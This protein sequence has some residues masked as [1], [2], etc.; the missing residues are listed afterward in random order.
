MAALRRAL[1]LE[2]GDLPRM[3]PMFGAYFL[4][5]TAIYV[6]KPARNAL[7]LQGE[8]VAGLPWVLLAVAGAGG[9]TAFAYGKI[10]DRL[11]PDKLVPATFGALA[12][13]LLAFRW[14]LATEARWALYAF[15]VF[16][17]LLGLLT[18][19]LIWL[20]ANSAFD[21][22]EARR[23]FGLIGTG[24]IIGSIVGG[25]LTGAVASRLGT[26]NLLLLAA[27]VLV[28]VVLVLRWAPPLRSSFESRSRRRRAA[29]QDDAGADE[30]LPRLLALNATIIGLV[31]VFVDVQFNSL[32]EK[33]FL[34]A[35]Q[36]AA[37]FGLFFAAISF[38][39][40]GVQLILTPW[41][42]RR[43]GLGPALAALPTA[44]GAGAGLLFAGP[45]F[46]F[47]AAPKAA[48]GGLRHSIHK[49][50]TE[51]VFLP[52]PASVKQRAKLFIDTTVDTAATGVGAL[53]VLGLTGPL[54]WSYAQ[55]SGPVL[56][57]AAVSLWTVGRLRSAY[58]DAFRRALET[59]RLDDT[60][61]TTGMNEAAVAE[62]LQTALQS[63]QPRQLVYLL[64]LAESVGVMGLSRELR[65]LLD[66]PSA[67]VRRRA[68]NLMGH[69]AD[70][71]PI[72]VLDHLIDHDEDPEVQ[73][74]ALFLRLR[75]EGREDAMV[76]MLDGS[77]ARAAAALRV[78]T[79]SPQPDLLTP[80]R[81]ERLRALPEA[82]ATLAS[83]VAASGLPFE[84]TLRGLLENAPFDVVDG[85][86]Q[87]MAKAQDPRFVPWLIE[88]LAQ[89]ELRGAARRTLAALGSI[90]V[91]ALS[92]L[93]LD[94]KAPL[95]A[96]RAAIRTLADVADGP[97]TEALVELLEDD[98]PIISG[99]ALQGLSRV[100]PRFLPR[101]RL[102][103]WLRARIRTARL[104]RATRRCLGGRPEP[105][106]GTRLFQR[107]LEEQWERSL[108]E[109]FSL[110][111][112]LHGREAMRDAYYGL[113]RARA[114]VLEYLDNTIRGGLKDELL[115][116]FE[117]EP[118]AQTLDPLFEAWMKQADP[119]LR[120]TAVYA[121]AELQGPGA[122]AGTRDLHP[123]VQET[124][125]HLEAAS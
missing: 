27:L 119:W 82:R 7:F 33:S 74:E 13:L 93:A 107:T 121:R 26:S 46:P 92:E 71:L 95:A 54:G 61:L 110:L 32:V 38:S 25:A 55:L 87:G 125:Q 105:G 37:F 88:A 34:E 112:L 66:H 60:A 78:L 91:P 120:A 104:I 8:G 45:G 98:Q 53:L 39:S 64:D 57:L 12:V 79:E 15:F 72:E 117:S 50:A 62:V 41:L 75:R 102:R 86:I 58:V 73:G 65:P 81:I 56:L 113:G 21:P 6:L 80:A 9:L 5:L 59:R 97:S 14:V 47:A 11:Q 63:S 114:E 36:K 24:G 109:I 35:E 1:G 42:L 96:R 76:A 48:D 90:S 43:F 83:A 16:V 116:L 49:A 85:A 89:R 115:G 99:A 40:L 101:R 30:R 103:R 23:V 52:V 124:L 118:K 111:G 3:A 17:Q 31:A 28:S 2:P 106:P 108:E 94:A 10:A 70:A 68:L 123:L 122:L 44:L 67:E 51:V 77:G 29:S 84:S 20:W 22:R 100:Q 19:S 4:T 69:Q 18:T